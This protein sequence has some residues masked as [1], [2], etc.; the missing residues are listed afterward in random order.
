MLIYPIQEVYD[1][2]T[3]GKESFNFLYE[4]AFSNDFETSVVSVQNNF[5]EWGKMHNFK[6]FCFYTHSCPAKWRNKL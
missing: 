5:K 2:S 6:S 1:T 3:I 4:R